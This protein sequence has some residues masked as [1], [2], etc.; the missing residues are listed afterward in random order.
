MKKTIL[1]FLFCTLSLFASETENQP[2]HTLY[3][4]KVLKSSQAVLTFEE[5]EEIRF[6]MIRNDLY[7]VW[8]KSPNGKWRRYW[9]PK[10]QCSCESQKI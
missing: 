6:F 7:E 1:I 9:R 8:I 5:L 3:E 2:Q 4:V 10:Q